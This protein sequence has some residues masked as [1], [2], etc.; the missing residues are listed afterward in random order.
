MCAREVSCREHDVSQRPG[1]VASGFHGALI[2]VKA[3]PE[4]PPKLIFV[5]PIARRPMN[6]L[7]EDVSGKLVVTAFCLLVFGVFLA[8]VVSN[9]A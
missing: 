2:P 5:N 4:E 7:N 1:S 8:I 3:I 6:T 9:L